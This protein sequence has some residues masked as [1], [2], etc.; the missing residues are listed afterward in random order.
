MTLDNIIIIYFQKNL[1]TIR[2]KTLL[3]Y[4]EVKLFDDKQD[5]Y[6]KLLRGIGAL[7]EYLIL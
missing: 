6:N 7:F 3:N 5:I 2:G 4:L 1:G